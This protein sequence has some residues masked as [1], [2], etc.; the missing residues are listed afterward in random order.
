[1]STYFHDESLTLLLGDV[2][3]QMRT[4][5]DGSVACVV[6]SPPYF[7]LRDYEG[8]PDQIGLEETPIEYV[9]ALVRVFTEV[10]R[11][12]ADDGTLWLNLGDSYNSIPQG[13]RTLLDPNLPAKSLLLIPDRVALALQ[14]AGW[15]F[16]NKIAWAKPNA[17]PEP[18]AD[19]L[20]SRHETV[21]MLV[22]TERYSF[23]LNAI[24]VPHAA[25]SVYQQ[26]VAR[27]N[28]HTPG[29][30]SQV[31]SGG[32]RTGHGAG[33]RDLHPA[34]ANPGDVWS[35][36]TRPFRGT[37]F[38]PFPAELPLRCIA[39]GCKPGGTVLD[40]FSGAGTTAVA[41]QQLG[42]PAIGIDINAAY[43]DIALRRMTNAPLPL[44]E[45]GGVA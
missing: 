32:T 31:Q 6:T 37:H 4:L 3:G 25:K 8:N 26:D 16:R 18:A 39:A 34:G 19:R 15:I 38:A 43:H 2:V 35:I 24:R 10:W 44:I 13:R 36:A 14:S 21:Y 17:R 30:A 23:N 42:H 5:G 28:P 27:R 41:A 45:G 12:L 11:V 40:P 33:L 7:G 1:M 22:K 20:S 9:A 29:K